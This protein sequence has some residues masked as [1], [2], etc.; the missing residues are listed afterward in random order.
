MKK[1]ICIFLLLCINLASFS[2]TDSDYK[3]LVEKVTKFINSQDIKSVYELFSDNLKKE[4]SFENLRKTILNHQKELGKI[5]STEFWMEGELGNCYLLEFEQ[6]TMVLIVKLL[7][8]NK[9]SVF[10]IEEY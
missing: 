7:P 8:E 2:Q 4:N 10:N 1:V 6:A 5:T 3:K 9:I